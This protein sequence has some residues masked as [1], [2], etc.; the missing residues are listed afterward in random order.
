MCCPQLPSLPVPICLCLPAIVSKVL[1]KA[2]GWL[3]QVQVSNNKVIVRWVHEPSETVFEPEVYSSHGFCAT[4]M[5]Q[6][7]C[8]CIKCSKLVACQI[9]HKEG[10]VIAASSP[11]LAFDVARTGVPRDLNCLIGKNLPLTEAPQTF[12]CWQA[13]GGQH[14][15]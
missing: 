10:K 15:Q 14:M 13:E 2:I 4:S 1:G 3:L 11:T 12:I 6:M 9:R 5:W 8:C 7:F